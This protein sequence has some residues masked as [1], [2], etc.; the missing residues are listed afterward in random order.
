MVSVEDVVL[1][2]P[3]VH[4]DAGSVVSW[5]L[6]P[7]A[8][9]FI[10]RTVLPGS[11]TLEV[12]VGGSTVVLAAKGCHHIAI[13]PFQVEVDRVVDWAGARGLSMDTVRF[14][15][16]RSQDVL[17]GLDVDDLDFALVD[18]DHAFPVPIVDWMYAAE[19]LAVD[20]VLLFDDVQ[21]WT[22][23][24]L[25]DFL[26]AE[27]GWR[28]EWEQSRAFAFRKLAGPVVGRWQD[29]PY[30]ARRSFRWGGDRWVPAVPEDPA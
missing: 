26:A 16:G 6:E 4:D 27:P 17:P 3:E 24:L 18:G 30:V 29:Q 22:G 1:S 7:E 21:I 8:L 5:K 19:R 20:G 2:P 28:L 13:T 11:R 14:A 10:D 12:G 15:I 25:R 23:R 9:R